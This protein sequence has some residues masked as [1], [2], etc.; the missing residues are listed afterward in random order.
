MQFKRSF[1]KSNTMKL[2]ELKTGKQI[3]EVLR[4][5]YT[6]NKLTI[7]QLAAKYEV[8]PVSIQKWLILFD[9]PRRHLTFM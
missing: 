3:H 8:S 2:I 5:D 6:N 1:K 4:E 7:K 9:I